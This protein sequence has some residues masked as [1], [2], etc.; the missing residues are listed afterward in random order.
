[1]SNTLDG[2]FLFDPGGKNQEGEGEGEGEIFGGIKLQIAVL[3]EIQLKRIVP[4]YR[5]IGQLTSDLFFRDRNSTTIKNFLV[6]RLYFTYSRFFFFF[7][8]FGIN[9]G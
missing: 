9:C 3:C 5:M 6:T 7:W 8:R 1:M 2:T 4:R